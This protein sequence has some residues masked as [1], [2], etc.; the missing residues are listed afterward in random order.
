MIS[1]ALPVRDARRQ[2]PPLV[3]HRGRHPRHLRGVREPRAARQGAE[4]PDQEHLRGDRRAGLA[5]GAQAPGSEAVRRRADRRR[6]ARSAGRT[7]SSA[8]STAPRRGNL[9][10]AARGTVRALRQRRRRAGQGQPAT[11]CRSA[12]A[13]PRP[14]ALVFHELA[15]N[16]GQIRRA[17]DRATARSRSRSPTSGKT[18]E[19]VSGARRGGKADQEGAEGRLRLAPGRHER[20]RPARRLVGAALRRRRAGVELT[21]PKSRSPPKRPQRARSRAS[22][23][24]PAAR[25]APP[26]RS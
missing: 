6:S 26:P 11:T 7:N 10:T 17:G 23:R 3:R 19:A 24:T 22:A 12:R 2:D 1:R 4:P 25:R 13:P 20:Q 9:R 16:S 18:R 8:R 14:L 5:V 21:L 15:T